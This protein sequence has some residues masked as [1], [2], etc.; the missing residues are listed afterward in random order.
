MSNAKHLVVLSKL[1]EFAA[2]HF[3]DGATNAGI[4][5]VKNQTGE[6]CGVRGRDFEG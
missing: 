2:N 6:F 3:G 4:G 1:T 5:F